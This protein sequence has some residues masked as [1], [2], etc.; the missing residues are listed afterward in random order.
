MKKK[1]TLL[2][3]LNS[4]TGK[5]LRFYEIGSDE[6]LF[7]SRYDVG[8]ILGYKGNSTSGRKTAP[9][10]LD[11]ALV[12][13]KNPPVK[14]L[15]S[16]TTYDAWLLC[17]DLNV[18]PLSIQKFVEFLVNAP[19]HYQKH[20][21]YFDNAFKLLDW[22]DGEII[23]LFY[24]ITP[25]NDEKASFDKKAYMREWKA[26]NPDRVR[27]YK[28]RWSEAHPEYQREYMRRWHANNP[29]Y[30]REYHARKRAEKKTVQSNLF[31]ELTP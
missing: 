17:I 10:L 4:P 1:A 22:L 25:T 3:T 8:K 5:P 2:G 6:R 26:K 23:P 24:E 19:R 31:E 7:V 9:S 15:I 16:S 20:N 30:M 14:C 13:S 12:A 27:E 21:L 29:D 18:L 11:R 28:R